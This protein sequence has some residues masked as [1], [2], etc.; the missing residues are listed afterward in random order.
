MPVYDGPTGPVIRRLDKDPTHIHKWDRE[1][2][3]DLLGS[4]F[5][6][7]D[8]Q[9]AFR[10]LLPSGPYLHVPTR[11]LRAVSPAILVVARRR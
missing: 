4:R 11:R 2:W 8:W 9:G 6:I 5:N 3:L 1:A 10:L 7:L